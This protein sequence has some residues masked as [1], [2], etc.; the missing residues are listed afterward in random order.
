MTGES[1]IACKNCKNKCRLVLSGILT[2]SPFDGLI[3]TYNLW[4]CDE[5]GGLFRE[6]SEHIKIADDRLVSDFSRY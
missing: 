4:Q 2:S 3:D 6:L 1:T 5:C